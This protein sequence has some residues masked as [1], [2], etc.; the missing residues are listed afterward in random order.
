MI[1]C[2]TDLFRSGEQFL[3]GL[4]RFDA[5]F[6]ENVRPVDEMLGVGHEGNRHHLAVDGDQL[7]LG[8]VLAVLGNQVVKRLDHILVEQRHDRRVGD[9]GGGVFGRIA[10]HAGNV[11]FLMI[12][13]QVCL[14]LDPV[15]G[16]LAGSVRHGVDGW[17]LVTD[18]A[19]PALLDP[20]R[21][22]GRRRTGKQD[23]AGQQR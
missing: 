23:R 12:G 9:D 5:D 22:P 17:K 6:F 11:D 8:N 15:T 14:D 16:A 21:R 2:L 3:I 18:N 20:A 7:V 4:R 1:T 10:G 19:D 13:S